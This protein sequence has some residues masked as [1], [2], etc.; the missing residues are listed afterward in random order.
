MSPLATRR[1]QAAIRGFARLIERDGWPSYAV[2]C[3]HGMIGGLHCK[4][5]G[6]VD[7]LPKSEK[8]SGVPRGR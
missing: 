2:Y 8:L 5:C 1:E 4:W 7:K 3:K 6:A